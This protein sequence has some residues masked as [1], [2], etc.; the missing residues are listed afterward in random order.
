MPHFITDLL[1]VISFNCN[2]IGGVLSLLAILLS[3]NLK[4][5]SLLSRIVIL[6]GL[7]LC[8]SIYFIY[9][10]LYFLGLTY[11]IVYVGAIA[12]LFLFIL[13]ICYSGLDPLGNKPPTHYLT[14]LLLLFFIYLYNP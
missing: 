7:Y 14:L 9:L 5:G 4:T 10:D 13:M 3:I 6:I 8:G 1:Q 2:F 12:I 11:I